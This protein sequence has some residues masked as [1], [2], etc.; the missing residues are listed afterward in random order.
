MYSPQLEVEPTML[1]R[2]HVTAVE[3]FAH[4]YVTPLVA[5]D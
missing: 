1:L 3:V 2:H 4:M 5:H